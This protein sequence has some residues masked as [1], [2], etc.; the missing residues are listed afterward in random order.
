MYD[1]ALDMILDHELGAWHAHALMC[2]RCSSL[3]ASCL[4]R[5]AEGFRLTSAG[6]LTAPSGRVRA[7]TH[8]CYESQKK[9]DTRHN[10]NG[11][12]RGSTRGSQDTGTLILKRPMPIHQST[13]TVS[14]PMTQKHMD[15][16]STAPNTLTSLSLLRTILSNSRITNLR[17]TLS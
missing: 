1:Q 7:H 3:F 12:N 4:A 5:A 13:L 8:T 14:A 6:G 10:V 16:S 17:K 2:A 15:R 9:R 11:W